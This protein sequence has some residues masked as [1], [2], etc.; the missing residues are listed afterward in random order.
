MLSFM[1]PPL[2]LD[3][4]SGL[5]VLDCGEANRDEHVKK[6]GRIRWRCVSRS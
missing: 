3:G 2:V 6:K 5:L 4:S 1:A